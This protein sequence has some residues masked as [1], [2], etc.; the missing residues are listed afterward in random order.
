VLPT[1]LEDFIPN[2]L[3]NPLGMFRTGEFIRRADLVRE[4]RAVAERGIPVNVAWSDRDRLVSRSAFDELRHAA[5]VEGVVIEGAH[6]WLIA[7]PSIFRELVI[8]SLVDSGVL[9]PRLAG[10]ATPRL[11]GG[12]APRLAGGASMPSPAAGGT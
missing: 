11:A 12:A 9:T 2:L 5:G 1:L 3:G 7:D 6:A 10:G 8:S 4:V